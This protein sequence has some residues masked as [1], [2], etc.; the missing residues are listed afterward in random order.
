MDLG[1]MEVA[2]KYEKEEFKRRWRGLRYEDIEFLRMELRSIQAALLLV[3]AV[4]PEQ[5]P[6]HL[7]N[8]ADLSREV[9]YDIQDILDTFLVRKMASPFLRSRKDKTRREIADAIRDVKRSV[10]MISY[11]RARYADRFAGADAIRVLEIAERRTRYRVDAVAANPAAATGV[12]SYLA[13]MP[14]D[15][16]I[17][18]LMD[19]DDDESDHRLRMVSIFGMGGVGKTT[20]ARAVYQKL[21]SQ[22]DCGAFVYLSLNPNMNKV[23]SN[24]LQQLDGEKYR[25]ITEASWDEGRLMDELRQLLQGKRYLIVI[26]DIWNSESWQTIR[27]AMVDNN[28]GSRIIT[29][30]RKIEVAK[31][32]GTVY[33]LQP[34]S[35]DDSKTLFYEKVFGNGGKYHDNQWDRT[36]DKILKKCNGL[37]LALL[38]IGGFLATKPR[39]KWDSIIDSV[40]EDHSDVRRVLR[41]SYDH[42]PSHLRAC[43]LYISVFPE[44]YEFRRD[45]LVWRWIAEG[46]IQGKQGYSLFQIGQ[47]YFEELLHRSMILQVDKNVSDGM[48]K[49]C[50]VHDLVLDLACSLATDENFVTKLV[51]EQEQYTFSERLKVRRL[52]LQNSQLSIQNVNTIHMTH[53][54]SVSAFGTGINLMP[55]LSSFEVLRVLDLEGCDLRGNYYDL[56]HLGELLHLRYLGLRG[57]NVA[58]LPKDIGNLRFLQ[59]LDLKGTTIRVLPSTVALLRKLLCLYTEQETRMTKGLQNLTSLEEL[60]KISVS[61]YPGFMKELNCLVE[62]RVL[63]IVL[64]KEVRESSQKDFMES[65]C[66]L[67]KIQDLRV[68]GCSDLDFM[69]EGWE[70]APSL[71]KFVAVDGW[72]SVLPTWASNAENLSELHLGVKELR[73]EDL[74][75][76]GRLRELRILRLVVERTG[77]RLAV[78]ADAFPTLTQLRFHGETCL[79]F[80]RG[81]MPKVA[82][83]EFVL[84]VNKANGD[85]DWGVSNLSS[86]ERVTVN[87]RSADGAS[88]AEAEDAL[89]HATSAHPNRP[90]LEITMVTP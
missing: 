10:E 79:L 63:H 34:L 44:D 48:T 85:F 52:S 13:G 73:R 15:E 14:T 75:S 67:H 62:L 47:I 38:T 9:S 55:P 45:R 22:F 19:I 20:L 24:M 26:D 90:T 66:N 81:A 39:E 71:R 4:P 76:L 12:D 41:L 58:Q 5:L 53:V 42:L 25:D 56:E 29:T 18:K 46:F 2:L 82:V 83:L 16:L 35:Y 78:D 87:L 33:E 30:T 80:R 37:P 8:W 88:T 86:L 3:G 31:Q 57:T 49:Y 84:D 28:L 89:K 21:I 59:I 54:R 23:F 1:A 74:Q 11:E 60:S 68:S 17:K 50:R 65:L 64:Q 61:E 7:K 36:I 72:F 43:F 70:P 40:L 77:E 6:Q 51:D 27:D 32:V 69:R